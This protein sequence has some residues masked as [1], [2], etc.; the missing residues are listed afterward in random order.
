MAYLGRNARCSC[1]K[2]F[3][4]MLQAGRQRAGQ[5]GSIQTWLK[6]Y[7][8]TW[9]ATSFRKSGLI[10]RRVLA[11]AASGDGLPM[12]SGSHSFGRAVRDTADGKPQSNGRSPLAR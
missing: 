10:G 3:A 8:A 7:F 5:E 1:P 9:S 2:R 6:N 11:E 12:V 4:A